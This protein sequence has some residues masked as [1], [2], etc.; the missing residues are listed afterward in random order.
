MNLEFAANHEG[1]MLA[2]F[3]PPDVAN[4]IA[5]PGGEP[6]DDLHVT[7]FYFYDNAKLTEADRKLILELAGK[8]AAE[9]PGLDVFLHGTTVFEENEERPLV[10]VVQSPI[11]ENYR[12]RL[13]V[14]L[15][16]AGIKYSKEH[17]YKPH[18]TL[19]YLNGDKPPTVQVEEYFTTHQLIARFASKG[20]PIPF[21]NFFKRQAP[22]GH[23]AA[24]KKAGQ[25]QRIGAG[26]WESKVNRQQRKLVRVF[27]EWVAGLKREIGARAKRGQT[28]P[29]LNAYLEE[30]I[31]KLESRLLEVNAAGV[32]S[33]AKTAAGDFIDRPAVQAKVDQLIREGETLVRENLVPK[34]HEKL[35]LGLA[36]A[37]PVA[38]V[39]GLA[40]EQQ[41]AIAL[42]IKNASLATRAAPAQ[43]AG[44][45]WVA[46][47]DVQ[48]T[49]GTEHEN[50]RRAQGLDIEPVR[51]EL[52]PR[53]EHCQPSAGFY[54]CPELAGEYPN[55]WS[56]L[57]TVPAGQVT[58]RGRTGPFGGWTIG[59]CR[60]HISVFRDGQWK[61]G[62]FD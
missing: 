61:R 37:V 51:W 13:A 2:V 4:R 10:A 15:D 14:A 18:L 22:R 57:R 3:A 5:I 50:E 56:S 29:Q 59:N 17:E 7:L 26:T 34:V 6:P 38:V 62:V 19:K 55:G 45:Y 9:Y 36:A 32:R 20:I 21:G 12:R 39:G 25:R 23:F 16:I 41:R 1:A 42:A 24:R 53:A 40:V 30:Q 43:Y 60:C 46:L 49:V 28:L 47:F 58:C 11:L 31:P 52:D 8:L 44:G 35:S 27:D 48:R 33:A 54:G